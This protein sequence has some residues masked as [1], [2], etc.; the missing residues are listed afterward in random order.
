MTTITNVLTDSIPTHWRDLQAQVGRILQEC[1]FSVEPEKTIETVRGSVDIDVYAQD[2][3]QK[4][5]TVFLCECKRWKSSVP[6]TVVHAFRTVISD[7]GANWGL[8]VSSRKFQKGA[9]EAASNSN[10]KLV[11]WSQF[12]EL[13][14]ERWIHSYMVPRIKEESDALVE[15][16]EPVNSRIFRKADALLP[17]AREQF[18]ALREK[19]MFIA[20]FALHLSLWPS[21]IEELPALPISRGMQPGGPPIEGGLPADVV[22]A[23]SLRQLLDTLCC[24]LQR[25]TAE[26]DKVFGER[27]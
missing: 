12:Q 14:V 8:I 7:Y 17:E 11:T 22:E 21:A 23:T 18:I 16:T 3:T 24:H 4:P 9:Y 6:K 26:F 10:V 25:G 15:Y 20:Y 5:T 2:T 1:G 19:Y 13:F 27:A